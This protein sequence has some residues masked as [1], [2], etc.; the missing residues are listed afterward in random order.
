MVD[1]TLE[2]KDLEEFA[3]ELS[4]GASDIRKLFRAEII[5]A[6]YKMQEVSVKSLKSGEKTGYTYTWRAIST[7]LEADSFR[8]VKGKV[9]PV[10]LRSKPHRASAKGEAPASDT[11]NLANS[12]RI[13][14]STGLK[15]TVNFNANYAGYLEDDLD[16]PFIQPA[17]EVAE[18]EL[19]KNIDKLIERALR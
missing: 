8:R 9:I 16:R 17:Y 1:L 5:F 10:K 15:A 12:V 7:G 6:A 11:G 4:D 19:M 3:K 14:E 2:V 13:R 18:E